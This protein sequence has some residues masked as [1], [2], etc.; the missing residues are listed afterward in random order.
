MNF[1]K[2]LLAAGA[3]IL[4]LASCS[5]E[6]KGEN[7][8]S[9]ADYGEIT[10]PDSLLYYFGQLRAADYWQFAKSDSV[11]SSRQS[12][13]EYLKGL[14]AGL[15]A[16]KDND[17]YNQGLYV[18]IQLA[19]NMKE[20]SEEY[21]VDLNRKIVYSAIEDGLLN[22]SAVN[23]AEAN[24]M[25]RQVLERLNMRKEENDRATAIATLSE[26]AKAGKWNKISD[27]LYGGLIKTPGEGPVVKEGDFVGVELEVNDT[28]G[29]EIDRRS[30]ERI[31]VGQ[32]FPGP[33]TEAISTMNIGEIRSFYTTGPAMFGRLS[34]RYN[35]KPTQILTFTVK[36]SAPAAP[37]SEETAE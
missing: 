30:M 18:G 31:K 14:R 11:L 22:D 3:A 19:M 37:V 12:R 10:T 25:F 16:A 4:L 32:S 7:N 21:G 15:D 8:R 29:K 23:T 28:D 36:L 33:V 5:N 9:L 13:D 2:S 17:A 24:R 34:S 1:S 6:K 26:A 20:F 27:T 35:V